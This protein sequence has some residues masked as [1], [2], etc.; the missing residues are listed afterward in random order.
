MPG[1][2]PQLRGV[3]PGSAA[4]ERQACRWGDGRGCVLLSLWRWWRGAGARRW[5]AAGSAGH[6]GWLA[7]GAH[8][9]RC[10]SSECRPSPTFPSITATQEFVVPRSMPMTASASALDTEIA[11][12]PASDAHTIERH[13][14]APWHALRGRAPNHPSTPVASIMRCLAH[15]TELSITP[16]LTACGHAKLVAVPGGTGARAHAAATG[17]TWCARRISPALAPR[18]MIVVP[19]VRLPV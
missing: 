10:A 11:L 17:L 4:R 13:A 8:G 3:L 16:W 12:R 19:G 6:V 9:C 14:G 1:A 5:Q 7:G 18:S 2:R 15:L